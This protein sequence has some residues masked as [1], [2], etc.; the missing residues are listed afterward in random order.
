MGQL[1]V[2]GL[3]K[4]Y[5]TGIRAL[6]CVDLTVAD[7]EVLALIGP[8]GCGKTTLLR[9]VAG[10]EEPDAGSI[11]ID[12]RRIERLPTRRREVG[13][14]VEEGGLYGNMTARSNIG[15]PLRVRSV[16]RTEI[17]DRVGTQ[18]RDMD[19][20]GLLDRRPR[21]LSAG[22]QQIVKAARAVVARPGVLL[23]DEPLSQVDPA[24][25]AGIRRE[26]LALQRRH[27]VTTVWVT[28]DHHEAF[29]VADRVAVMMDGD[30][31]QI[32]PLAQLWHQPVD[33][34]VA[35]FMGEPP[36]VLVDA[37]VQR[38]A[39]GGYDL[40]IG[41]GRVRVWAEALRPFAGSYVTAGVRPEQVAVG[42]P[43][44]MNAVVHSVEHL[45]TGMKIVLSLTDGTSQQLAALVRG[46]WLRPGDRV[47]VR[48]PGTSL[49]VFDPV[50]G[51]ALHHP[52]S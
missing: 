22:E 6:G 2:E 20:E 33:A 19:I 17:A 9:L 34:T 47:P 3:T 1:V 28:S 5:P 30:L 12:G 13:M 41:G 15:F 24:E 14:V 36:M 44:D 7:G 8:S 16:P 21:E 11:A 37:S 43:S 35:E 38:N 42:E 31:R 51:R 49:H 52:L 26:L 10:L 46:R 27:C 50:S 23:M 48:V 25:R 18:A 45:P 39:D 40:L 29:A 32:G 4:L